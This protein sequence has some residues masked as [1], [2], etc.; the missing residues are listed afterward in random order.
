MDQNNKIYNYAKLGI[1]DN[2]ARLDIDN[3]IILWEEKEDAVLMTKFNLKGEILEQAGM[4]KAKA[5]SHALNYSKE[6]KVAIEK[7]KFANVEIDKVCPHCGLKT[8]KR[9]SESAKNMAEVPVMPMYLCSNCGKRSFYLTDEYLAFL[10]DNNLTL[11]NAA[12]R[13]AL[14]SKKEETLREIK[15]TAK[16]IFI[17]KGAKQII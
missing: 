14:K 11:F 1:A 4:P 5:E 17:A 15:E 2:T 10:A 9:I 7:V 16:R 6:K 12:E 13:E 8:L 3:F